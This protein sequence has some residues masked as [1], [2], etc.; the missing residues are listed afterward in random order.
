MPPETIQEDLTQELQRHPIIERAVADVRLFSDPAF[1][2]STKASIKKILDDERTGFSGTPKDSGNEMADIKFTLSDAK[3]DEMH[4][5]HDIP[6]GQNESANG[7]ATAMKTSITTESKPS[8]GSPRRPSL[9]TPSL[10]SGSPSH[11]PSSLEP[12][13]ISSASQSPPSLEPISNA[14]PSSTT[15]PTGKFN[16]NMTIGVP[17][18]TDVEMMDIRPGD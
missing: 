12:T 7:L 5:A 2:A 4:S 9:T 13:R 1:L 3:Q 8:V 16:V 6:G 18:T 10:P 14:A 11:A 17:P 15:P